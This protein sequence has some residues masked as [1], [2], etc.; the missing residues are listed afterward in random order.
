MSR[1]LYIHIGA[2]KTAT[3]A[4]QRACWKERGILA[5][6][7]LLYPES[8]IYHFGHHRLAFALKSRPD[9]KR[10]D[11]PDMDEEIAA[12][13]DAIESADR[14][15]VLISSEA[16]FVMHRAKLK[17]LRA[18]L[19]GIDVRVLAFVRRQDDYLL[20]LYNQN[21]RMIGNDFTRPLRKY[22]ADPR[23]IGGEISF[24]RWLNLWRE[25]FGGDAVHLWR[26]EDRDPLDAMLEI[27]GLPEGLIT[28]RGGVN[29]SSPAVVVEAVR[30]AKR[31]GLPRRV[32]SAVRSATTRMFA[33]W[34]RRRLSDSQRASILDVFAEE[35]DELFASFDM[36]NTYRLS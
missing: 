9:P 14:S 25:V 11:V 4:V 13:R 33:N 32:Q 36:E 17:R 6:N 30:L 15:R 34:P 16:F 7:D 23:S 31:A 22:V 26:Y 18:A 3:T 10:G 19:D 29:A 27:I 21:A 28:T 12:L 1:R 2:H 20:S 35:N 5:Q 24:L 8:N